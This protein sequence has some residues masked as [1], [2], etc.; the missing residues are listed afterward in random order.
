M[1]MEDKR[2][3]CSGRPASRL[4]SSQTPPVDACGNLRREI[5]SGWPRRSSPWR[6]WRL[7]GRSRRA[8]VWRR[9]VPIISFDDALVLYALLTLFGRHGEAAWRGQ[10]DTGRTRAAFRAGGR[11]VAFRHRSQLCERPALLAHIFVRRHR[12]PASGLNASCGGPVRR[13]RGKLYQS[14]AGL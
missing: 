4:H 10:D 6:T 8:H 2:R 5:Q 1:G 7:L 3:A 13:D 11:Q 9:F 12:P 14:T